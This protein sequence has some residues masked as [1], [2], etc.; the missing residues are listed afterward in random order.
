MDHIRDICRLQDA[1]AELALIENEEHTRKWHD[2]VWLMKSRW[3]SR[4]WVI[5]EIALAKQ[6]SV[7]SGDQEVDWRNFNYAISFLVMHFDGIRNLFRQSEEFNYNA[8]AIDDLGPLGAK[9]LA[10]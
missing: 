3:F 10:D 6:A 9:L 1:E 4:R 7:R 5:Q 8:N 2:L